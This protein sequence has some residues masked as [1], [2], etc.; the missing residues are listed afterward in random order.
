LLLFT[1]NQNA[2]FR[3]GDGMDQSEDDEEEL[4]RERTNQRAMRRS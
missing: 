1:A 2:A 4:A 3:K